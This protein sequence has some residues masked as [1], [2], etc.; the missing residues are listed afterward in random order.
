[1]PAVAD[2]NGVAA[3]PPLGR[4]AHNRNKSSVLR[5]LM[6]SVTNNYG[7]SGINSSK[8]VPA[9]PTTVC[10]FS[11][12]SA[13]MGY[14]G[15]EY[16]QDPLGELPQNRQDQFPRIVQPSPERSPERTSS[17]QKSSFATISLKSIGVKDSSKSFKPRDGSPEKP[18]KVKSSTNLGDLLKRPKS[19]KNFKELI[20]DD[21]SRRGKEKD[22]ENRT[23]PSSIARDYSAPPPIYAQFATSQQLQNTTCASPTSYAAEA[24]RQSFAAGERSLDSS[25]S[26]SRKPR[27]KSFQNYA[28]SQKITSQSSIGSGDGRSSNDMDERGRKKSQ[29]WGK[30]VPSRPSVKNAFGFGGRTKSSTSV[31]SYV[32]E[33][34]I[35]PKDIDKHLEA[36]LDR[37]N[38]PEN[39]RYKMRNLNNTIKMEF[40]RQDWAETHGQLERPKSNESNKTTEGGPDD[41]ED[42]K[43]KKHSRGL[44]LTLS[45]NKDK[46]ASSS[47]P[48]K[49]KKGDSSLGRHFRTKSTD[50]VMSDAGSYIGM[51][52]SPGGSVKKGK[53]QGPDD[54]VSYLRTVQKP[55]LVEVGKLHKLRLLLRNETVAWIEEFIRLGGMK[56]IVELLYRIMA[57]EWR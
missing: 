12:D 44:S 46:A 45:R 15:S 37:R 13:N 36:M 21:A 42:K 54:F 28:F 51:P 53:G 39:Q 49:K 18:K 47:S 9:T 34:V 27:P 2:L 56:E 50:S 40:I 16:Q 35:D 4:P 33:P 55:Q 26:D 10:H 23:P 8:S 30:P 41:Q 5:N 19:I 14:F 17:P 31:Q 29:T 32:R 11:A 52:P 48:T 57:V 7:G 25:T 43:K 3:Q 38:I 6:V 24:S 1:M 22:K 20:T